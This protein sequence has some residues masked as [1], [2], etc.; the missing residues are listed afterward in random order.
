MD[1]KPPNFIRREK[2]TKRRPNRDETL[3]IINKPKSPP[4][5][6][7]EGGGWGNKMEGPTFKK[8]KEPSKTHYYKT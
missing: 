4:K 1:G 8:T 2:T 3:P 5:K 7:G 6:R